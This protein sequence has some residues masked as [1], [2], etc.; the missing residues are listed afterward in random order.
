[1]TLWEFWMCAKKRRPLARSTSANGR[2]CP[3]NTALGAALKAYGSL[4]D[5]ALYQIG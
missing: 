3:E 4:F 1:V 5:T 2:L